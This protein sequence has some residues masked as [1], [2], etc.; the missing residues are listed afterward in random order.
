[1]SPH[2]RSPPRASSANSGRSPVIHLTN[3]SLPNRPPRAVAPPLHGPHRQTPGIVEQTFEGMSSARSAGNGRWRCSHLGG[4]PR[5]EVSD[6]LVDGLGE[7]R[8]GEGGVVWCPAD[9]GWPAECWFCW[10]AWV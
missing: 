10:Q 4:N 6:S 5:R 8:I 7:W 3:D 2:A 9:A 1:Q